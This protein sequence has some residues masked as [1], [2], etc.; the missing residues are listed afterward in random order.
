MDG[1]KPHYR[2]RCLIISIIMMVI[3]LI[4]AIGPNL[5]PTNTIW[6]GGMIFK[7]SVFTLTN[8]LPSPPITRR[9][10]NL[11]KRGI[12]FIRRKE[13]QNYSPSMEQK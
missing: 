8:I 4:I 11:G 7:T 12:P 5:D 2:M 10:G 6:T 13:M 3:Y 9:I 1:L